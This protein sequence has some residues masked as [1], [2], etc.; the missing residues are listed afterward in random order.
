MK[1]NGIVHTASVCDHGLVINTLGGVWITFEQP[2]YN[3]VAW[4]WWAITPGQ[5]AWLVLT[6]KD[7]TRVRVRSVKLSDRLFHIGECK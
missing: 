4:L 3:F 2:W 1:Q 5:K 7:G 6:R